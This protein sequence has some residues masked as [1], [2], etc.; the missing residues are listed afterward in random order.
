MV[1]NS[2][3]NAFQDDIRDKV[4][5]PFSRMPSV[6]KVKKNS[7]VM[8]VQS[9]SAEDLNFFYSFSKKKKHFKLCGRRIKLQKISKEISSYKKKQMVLHE[10]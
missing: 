8:I 7:C 9:L 4:K 2:E 6:E 3:I 5:Y 1:S 10:T